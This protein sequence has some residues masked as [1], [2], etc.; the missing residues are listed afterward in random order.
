[1]ATGIVAVLDRPLGTF[2]IEEA[3]VPDMA[4]GMVLLWQEHGIPQ[5]EILPPSFPKPPLPRP[6]P[7]GTP[8]A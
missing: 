1:M 4:P 8:E 2:S 6:S 7:Q 3:R 5:L